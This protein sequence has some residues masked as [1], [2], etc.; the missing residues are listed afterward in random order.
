MN[1][2]TKSWGEGGKNKHEQK[3]AS[4]R[5]PT[6]EKNEPTKHETHQRRENKKTKPNKNTR[7][8]AKKMGETKKH[9]HNVWS[10]DSKRTSLEKASS[11][12]A[13][14]AGTCT[15]SGSAQGLA[16]TP[17]RLND[18][19]RHRLY[20]NDYTTVTTHNAQQGRDRTVG[21]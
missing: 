2:G 14:S 1:D 20:M 18:T 4:T 13:T 16:S 3:R 10:R 6:I 7:T 19:R 15:S 17:S 11:V 12:A 8:H 21:G 9:G 5:S